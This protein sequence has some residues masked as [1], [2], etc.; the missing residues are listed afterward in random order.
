MSGLMARAGRAARE[1]I[2]KRAPE[3]IHGAPDSTVLVSIML[4]EAFTRGYMAGL[5]QAEHTIRVEIEATK[6][7]ID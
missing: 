3:G 5:D 4:A 1:I 7:Q 6:G 2:E